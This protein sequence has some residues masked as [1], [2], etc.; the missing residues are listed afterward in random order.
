[1]TRN[2]AVFEGTWAL[3]TEGWTNIEA[4]MIVPTTMAVALVSP[5]ERLSSGAVVSMSASHPLGTHTWCGAGR[6]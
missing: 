6:V 4:P 3:I 1:H 5:M 2:T